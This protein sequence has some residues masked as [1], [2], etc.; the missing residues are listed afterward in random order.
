[1]KQI[2]DGGGGSAS[3]DDIV[4]E[5]G[6]IARVIGRTERQTFHLLSA[7][8]LPAKKIGGRWAASRRK[9]LAAVLG[10]AA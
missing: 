9:L 3:S 6:N 10:D 7:G 5:V 2:A 4:W 8:H 1:M